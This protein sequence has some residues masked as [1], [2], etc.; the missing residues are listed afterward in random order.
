MYLDVLPITEWNGQVLIGEAK[1]EIID[2]TVL[3]KR[4][5]NTQ[6]MNLLLEADKV[7]PSHMEQLAEKLST[8][9]AFT[10]AVETPLNVHLLWLKFADILKIGDFLAHELHP[11]VTERIDSAVKFSQKFLERHKIRLLERHRL[12]FTIDAHGDLHSKN[13]FLLDEPIIFDC[14][15]FNDHMRQVDV[16]SELA[17]FCMD[18]DFYGKEDLEAHFLKHY[19]IKYPCLF[20]E[21]DQLLFQYYKLYRANVRLKVNALKAMQE[22]EEIEKEKRLGLVED[23]FT[24]MKR[25]LASLNHS[26]KEASLLN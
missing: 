4:M 17:F 23:Y 20:N 22:E 16:L 13:I 8:F 15:E 6:Q 9:H 21:E 24:L 25:Y 11:L 3:M 19:F 5:D 10:D 18:L 1:G 12:G 2:Y 7:Y 26:E 14:I